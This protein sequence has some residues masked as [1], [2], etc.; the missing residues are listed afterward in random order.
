MQIREITKKPHSLKTTDGELNIIFTGVH[1]AF[2]LTGDECN[3]I[4]VC[5][6]HHVAVDMGTGYAKALLKHTGLGLG[7]INTLLVTHSHGDHCGNVEKY[8]QWWMYVE[9]AHKGRQEKPNL[10]VTPEYGEVL[11][12]QSISG[13]LEFNEQYPKLTGRYLNINDYF[14]LIRPTPSYPN[15]RQCWAVQHGPIEFLMFR[16]KHIPDSVPG[17][18]SS[19]FSV[20][21]Y[22]PRYRLLITCDS[23]WDQ[24]LIHE[25]GRLGIDWM[26][27]DVAFYPEG[28]HAN[29]DLLKNGLSPKMKQQ[30]IL[31]H[32]GDE[33]PKKHKI[34][35]DGF[36]SWAQPGVIYAFNPAS[37]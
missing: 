12:R 9:R 6:E 23:R 28:V 34:E 18:S 35:Q 33:D 7:D 31:M 11:W 17:W 8:A 29:Y 14:E 21:L 25:F 37:S 24:E 5:G 1:G 27:H 3:F 10:I 20:G 13:G 26:F 2:T 16:T 4:V 32:Y 19:F 15:F 30:T 36:H 22:F